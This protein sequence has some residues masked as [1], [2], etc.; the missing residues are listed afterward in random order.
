VKV[1]HWSEAPWPAVA[2]A[3]ADDPTILF[4]IGA[5]EAHGP[6]LSNDADVVIAE[7]VARRAA[8]LIAADGPTVLVLPALAFGV[9]RAARPFPGT[10]GID[11]ELLRDLVVSICREVVQYGGKWFCWNVHHWDP[12]H[13]AALDEAIAVVRSWEDVRC[14]SFDRRSLDDAEVN[15]RF[16]EGAGSGI[17]HGGRTETGMVLAD[18]PEHVRAEVLATLEPVWIDLMEQFRAGATNFR[19][20]GGKDAYFGDPA[21]ATGEEGMSLLEYLAAGVAGLARQVRD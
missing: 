12:P 9:C 17:R 13:L 15:R 18:R 20:A 6:H 16:A 19:E 11:P 3:L 5:T 1:V 10:L 4:P 21:G 2:A 7:G 14:V 8:E